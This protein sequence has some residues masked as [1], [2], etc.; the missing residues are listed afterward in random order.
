M[1]YLYICKPLN[2]SPRG[3]TTSLRWLM[4][5]ANLTLGFVTR[6]LY[7]YLHLGGTPHL[8]SFIIISLRYFNIIMKATESI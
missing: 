5:L 6:K 8:A 7:E 4:A 1:K 2:P 3:Y